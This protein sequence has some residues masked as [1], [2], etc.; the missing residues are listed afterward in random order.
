[1]PVM[2]S[3]LHQMPHKTGKFSD[4]PRWCI[5]ILTTIGLQI[6]RRGILVSITVEPS[7]ADLGTAIRLG[8]ILPRYC[9]AGFG[10]TLEILR[11]D[12][13]KGSPTCC[14]RQGRLAE[15]VKPDNPLNN[16]CRGIILVQTGKTREV[17]LFGRFFSA[18]ILS[19]RYVPK[20]EIIA[21]RTNES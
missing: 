11:R 1:M 7:R 13:R 10:V 2:H 17:I 12:R 4:R 18:V 14:E 20:L 19:R 6:D 5:A 15:A 3:L 9:L 8:V 16:I 21:I